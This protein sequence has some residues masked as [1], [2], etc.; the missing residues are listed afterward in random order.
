LTKAQQKLR[1]DMKHHRVKSS[2]MSKF[3]TIIAQR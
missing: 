3:S 2:R 1:G